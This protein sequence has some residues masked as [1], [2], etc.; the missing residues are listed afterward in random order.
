MPF[1][2]IVIRRNYCYITYEAE[3]STHE[4]RVP[5]L[6]RQVRVLRPTRRQADGH[7][8]GCDHR[9]H[10]YPGKLPAAQ[11]DVLV[12]DAPLGA[13]RRLI[14]TAGAQ[15]LA[16]LMPLRSGYESWILPSGWKEQEAARSIGGWVA[17]GLPTAYVCRSKTPSRQAFLGPT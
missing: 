3:L 15:F 4:R 10:L 14:L 7:E 1:T 11:P 6:R 17:R 13:E 2:A 8:G 16:Q 5:N 9:V 12:A